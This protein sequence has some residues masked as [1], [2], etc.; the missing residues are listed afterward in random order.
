MKIVYTIEIWNLSRKKKYFFKYKI[1]ERIIY[2]VGMVQPPQ[3][4]HHGRVAQI[5]EKRSSRQV[6][7]HTLL[8]SLIKLRNL[9]KN[10]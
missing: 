4:G 5:L 9:K 1:K 2:V 6:D 10:I 7:F 8:L 3:A